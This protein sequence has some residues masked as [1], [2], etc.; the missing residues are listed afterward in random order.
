MNGR[1]RPPSPYKTQIPPV[2]SVEGK[3]DDPMPHEVDDAMDTLQKASEIQA[4]PK[5]MAH[6]HQATG[7][8]IMGLKTLRAL[9]GKK[10]AQG[11]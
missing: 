9:A 4:N 8:K 7:K 6:V 10:R 2:D 1:G 3:D 5:M 11:L